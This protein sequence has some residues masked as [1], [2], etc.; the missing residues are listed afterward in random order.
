MSV[1]SGEN[2]S[3]VQEQIKDTNELRRN[4]PVLWTPC[5]KTQNSLKQAKD[6]T[7]LIEP[8]GNTVTPG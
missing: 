2:G 1:E 6:A 5:S 4:K 3:K 8:G 7:S